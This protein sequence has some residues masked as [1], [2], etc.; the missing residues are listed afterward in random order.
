MHSPS[1]Q[2]VEL[3]RH[4]S[5]LEHILLGDLRDLLEEPLD[6]ENARWLLAVL[7]GLL[8]TV[9]REFALKEDGGYLSD[10]IEEHPAWDQYVIALRKDHA[11][12]SFKLRQLRNRVAWHLPTDRIASEV[13]LELMHWMDRLAAH[14]NRETRIVQDSC[15]VQV[16]GE[17]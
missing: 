16:G 14:Y 8:D 13:R 5:A 12:L 15:L 4:Y 1:P 10:V 9:P 2:S 11:D 17:E 6:R 7:D 3:L